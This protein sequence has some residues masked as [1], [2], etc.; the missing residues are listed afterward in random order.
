MKLAERISVAH[1]QSRISKGIT[2]LSLPHS[3]LH[4]NAKS[5]WDALYSSLNIKQFS[6]L[7][8]RSF[9]ELTW[10]ITPRTKNG[11]APPHSE[12]R[13]SL[14]NN[15]TQYQ[16]HSHESSNMNS[17][18]STTGF[19]TATI[20]IY[21]IGAGVTAAAGTRLALQLISHNN[22]VA[23]NPSTEHKCSVLIFLVT[24]SPESGLDNL[25]ACCLP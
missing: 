18:R 8:S 23:L 25:R 7:R 4:S 14:R 24:V 2:D 20:L 11:H 17:K 5:L 16:K 13:Y 9:M 3:S 1:E 6:R 15:A 21:A 12:V 10:Q 19:L 22:Q